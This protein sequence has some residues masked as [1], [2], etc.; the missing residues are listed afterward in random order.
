L[1]LRSIAEV[2]EESDLAAAEVDFAIR[3]VVQNAQ[4]FAE[5]QGDF[6]TVTSAVLSTAQ[7]D[8]KKT[9]GKGRLKKMR[10]GKGRGHGHTHEGPK[11]PFY[12]YDEPPFNSLHSSCK[13]DCDGCDQTLLSGDGVHP[14]R[15]ED[16]KHWKHGDDVWFAQAALDKG[17]PWRVHD[18]KAAE[19]FVIPALVNIITEF[20]VYLNPAGKFGGKLSLCCGDT[21]GLDLFEAMHE[22]LQTLPTFHGDAKKKHV[23]IASHYGAKF[24]LAKYSTFTSMSLISFEGRD[25]DGAL[26]HQIPGLYVSA[27]CGPPTTSAVTQ[28]EDVD[29]SF[30]FMGQID[31]RAAYVDRR[32]LCEAISLMP[33]IADKSICASTSPE[34]RNVFA[35]TCDEG[36]NAAC[37]KERSFG[38]DGFYCKSFLSHPFEL[39]VH[40]D[41]PTSGRVSEAIDYG[42]IPLLLDDSVMPHLPFGDRVPWRE[43]VIVLPHSNKGSSVAAHKAQL[44]ALLDLDELPSII[45]KLREKADAYRRMVSWS[46]KGSRVFDMYLEEAVKLEEVK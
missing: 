40:G 35:A 29:P 11:V 14:L 32:H 4:D 24:F 2:D 23:M 28:R 7:V 21:C 12:V 37:K 19:V 39:C 13:I 43:L 36:S 15:R 45:T 38:V 9:K 44:E 20:E 34:G 10:R 30:H 31:G 1:Q 17:H 27:N 41:T 5:S 6:H 18:P 33:G 3:Q 26:K 16:W 22:K 8:R 42:S 25:W 46:V